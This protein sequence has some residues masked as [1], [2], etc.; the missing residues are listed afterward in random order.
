MTPTERDLLA[1]LQELDRAIA[2]MGPGRPKPD[3]VSLFERIDSL[4][5]QL[6][7]AAG[8]DLLHYLYRKSYEKA[9]LWLEGREAENA[10]GTCH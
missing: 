1:S 10:R 6:P 8:Q 7:K 5:R 4:T 9:H 3:L 2:E